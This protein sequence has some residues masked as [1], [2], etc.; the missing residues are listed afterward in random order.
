MMEVKED[1]LGMQYTKKG[2]QCIQIIFFPHANNIYFHFRTQLSLP[3]R[4]KPAL[5]L[6][7][8]LVYSTYSRHVS[9]TSILIL[10]LIL[11]LEVSLYFFSELT[12]NS[13]VVWPICIPLVSTLSLFYHINSNLWKKFCSYPCDTFSS[14]VLLQCLLS[15]SSFISRV[16]PASPILC[17]SHRVIEIFSYTE[18]FNIL[19]CC[20]PNT[21]LSIFLSGLLLSFWNLL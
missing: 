10:L 19:K 15:L 6:S 1:E 20:N 14:P 16:S 5:R 8:N 3:C 9:V 17:I 11:L 12:L 13:V 7:E 2:E 4:Q 21:S 18:H